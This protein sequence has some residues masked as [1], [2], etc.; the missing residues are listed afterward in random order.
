MSQSGQK[1]VI[2]REESD[3][4]RKKQK[5]DDDDE[6]DSDDAPEESS[7]RESKDEEEA[8]SVDANDQESEEHDDVVEEGEREEENQSARESGMIVTISPDFK[9]VM[10]ILGKSGK[11]LVVPGY[12][13]T[14]NI[15]QLV[16]SCMNY[17]HDKMMK[18]VFSI[19]K[20]S[21]E[22]YPNLPFFGLSTRGT[23]LRGVVTYGEEYATKA[24]AF[25]DYING[26][27]KE[28]T[29]SLMKVRENE[30]SL[31][32]LSSFPELFIRIVIVAISETIRAWSLGGSIVPP[33]FYKYGS[34]DKFSPINLQD[35]QKNNFFGNTAFKERSKLLFKIGVFFISMLNG[36]RMVCKSWNTT[37]L[38]H[39]YHLPLMI[40]HQLGLIPLTI[41]NDNKCCFN[42]EDY[43]Q[44]NKQLTD[45]NV[46]F[47]PKLKTDDGIADFIQSKRGLFYATFSNA[48]PSCGNLLKQTVSGT[49]DQTDVMSVDKACENLMLEFFE[50][51]FCLNSTTPGAI[52]KFQKNVNFFK[53]LYFEC[54]EHEKTM[55]SGS[56]FK[57]PWLFQKKSSLPNGSLTVEFYNLQLEPSEESKRRSKSAVVVPVVTDEKKK[58]K[59]PAVKYITTNFG[60]LNPL[61]VEIQNMKLYGH[62]WDP[63]AIWHRSRILNV[64]LSPDFRFVKNQT[65]DDLSWQKNQAAKIGKDV[66][67]SN[68][69]Y[70]IFHEG[71]CSIFPKMWQI[72]FQY[73]HDEE[74]SFEVKSE[75]KVDSKKIEN[76]FFTVMSDNFT[77]PISVCPPEIT[78]FPTRFSQSVSGLK[79]GK[80]FEKRV[81]TLLE[82]SIQECYEKFEHQLLKGPTFNDS[83]LSLVEKYE[84]PPTSPKAN[85]HIGAY[86]SYF[87][88]AYIK[89]YDGDDDDGDEMEVD[90]GS[91]DL[92][93]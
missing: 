16:N 19:G 74:Y 72:T 61:F 53:A 47:K 38:E 32:E 20:T 76:T 25:K 34:S 45:L 26:L 17:T 37:I 30:E 79:K 50:N 49:V 85:N 52:C 3:R 71:Y 64:T 46:I 55:E 9:V 43:L 51:S 80:K 33:Y 62:D 65:K 66:I 44:Y 40:F 93:E 36:I 23:S 91:C 77:Y 4:P 1:R 14:E 24:I 68:N 78:S 90:E 73:N 69:F 54:I 5:P 12:P 15:Q 56:E 67:V 41:P 13:S 35:V 27:A 28:F 7:S 18:D 59:K 75:D 22:V 48:F 81:K 6:Q 89:F 70:P 29:L 39:G 83:K 31:N 57:Y 86:Q 8:K 58:G 82:K 10:D 2:E 87:I 11:N 63:Y 92:Y 42:I 88:S 21:C 84:V 60:K